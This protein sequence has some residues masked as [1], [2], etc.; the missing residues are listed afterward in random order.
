[1][2]LI[3]TNVLII[4]AVLLLLAIVTPLFSP[5]SR[6]VKD[7]RNGSPE[8]ST[9]PVSIIL[10]VHDNASRLEKVLDEYLNQDYETFQLIVVID[11]HD[12]ASEEILKLHSGNTHLY[13][14]KL[15]ESSRYLSRKKLAITLGMR[16]AKYEWVIV[17]SVYCKPTHDGWLKAF[18]SY[19]DDEHNM[20][21]GVT[22]FE[23]D[24]PSAWRFENLRMMLH[25]F[26][27]A[28]KTAYSTNQSV[29]ALKRNTFLAQNGFVGNLQYQRAEFEFLVNKFA[30]PGKTALAISEESWLEQCE[31]TK[32]Q[33]RYRLMH[34]HD[35][36]RDMQRRGSFNLVCNLELF[37][38]YL[39]NA[40][41]IIVLC[42]TG[43]F[44]YD[45]VVSQNMALENMLRDAD[46]VSYLTI[47]GL[48]LLFWILSYVESVIIFRQTIRY[49][50]Q[51]SAWSAP[52]RQ[53]FVV[54]RKLMC[55][56]HYMHT[57][58]NDFRTHKV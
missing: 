28:R 43:V 25:N 24:T 53:L 29:V 1:M 55:C 15:P 49:F 27:T 18:A 45:K 52:L 36:V 54:W 20:V 40:L 32:K 44:L 4:I 33:W 30:E 31:P 10:T 7:G 12:S 39:Y 5:F 16:A 50:G 14:T 19:M 46:S 56:I 23:E 13:Y 21:M 57:D 11:E 34:A 17:T 6:R 3:S 42:V 51:T 2:L 8:T 58:K 38:L 48:T 41:T 47:L 35:S 22:P 9:P 26:R 37:L